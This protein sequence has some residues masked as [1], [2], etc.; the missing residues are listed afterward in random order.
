ML[1]FINC[2]WFS[3]SDYFIMG[4]LDVFYLD[5]KFRYD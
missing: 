1:S 5:Q 4:S 3:T 2:Y